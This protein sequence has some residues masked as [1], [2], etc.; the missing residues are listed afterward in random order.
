MY[1]PG[2]AGGPPG[3]PDGYCSH[4]MCGG[5]GNWG[6]T[7][8]EV[9]APSVQHSGG[10]RRPTKQAARSRYRSMDLWPLLGRI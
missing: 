10:L 6:E 9:L 8:L 7:E 4:G 3:T 2:G 1:N 5:S